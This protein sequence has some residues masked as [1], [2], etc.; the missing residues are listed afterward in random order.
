MSALMICVA[1][2]PENRHTSDT[3]DKETTEH[4]ELIDVIGLHGNQHLSDDVIDDGSSTAAETD[5][6]MLFHY[7]IR[8]TCRVAQ[9][10]LHPLKFAGELW[11][12]LSQMLTD[13]KKKSCTTG[14]GIKFPTK[15]LH[16]FPQHLKHVATLPR[17]IQNAKLSQITQKIQ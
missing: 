6:R 12:E 5:L 13:S 16:Y 14:K 17:E 4:D 3:P 1:Y 8:L 10:T 2:Q 9:I 11:R 15:Y 7:N